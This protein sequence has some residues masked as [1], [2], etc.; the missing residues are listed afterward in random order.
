MDDSCDYVKFTGR[1]FSK[2]NRVEIINMGHDRRNGM[3]GKITGKIS[4]TIVGLL[5]CEVDFGCGD[6]G[7]FSSEKLNYLQKV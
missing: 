6:L 5:L 7:L 1:I 4:T 3:V 2:G